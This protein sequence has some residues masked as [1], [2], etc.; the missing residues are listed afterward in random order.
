MLSCRT[1]ALMPGRHHFVGY[2]ASLGAPD[3][4]ME[5]CAEQ[6]EGER[7]SAYVTK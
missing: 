4:R 5:D 2:I 6:R 3:G 1:G 7:S